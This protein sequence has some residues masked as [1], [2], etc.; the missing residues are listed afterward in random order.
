MLNKLNKPSKKKPAIEAEDMKAMFSD[1]ESAE[2]DMANELAGESIGESEDV[3][4]ESISELDGVSDEELMAELRKRGLASKA[5]SAS[6]KP[7]TDEEYAS[8]E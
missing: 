4:A 2:G 6:K 1:E 7:S 8:F 3:E 5:V